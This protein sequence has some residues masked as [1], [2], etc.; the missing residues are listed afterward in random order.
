[1]TDRQT[2]SARVRKNDRER[3][4]EGE[5]ESKREE[6]ILYMVFLL[7]IL[8]VVGLLAIICSGSVGDDDLYSTTT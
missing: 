7:I 4:I 5:Q 2:D 1:M 3:E 6:K 8:T